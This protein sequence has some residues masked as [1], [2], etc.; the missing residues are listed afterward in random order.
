MAVLQGLCVYL[1]DP[2]VD[3]WDQHFDG[4]GP[5]GFI[6]K[7]GAIIGVGLDNTGNFAGVPRCCAIKRA[8]DGQILNTPAV[9]STATTGED[10]W[11]KIKIR[12]DIEQNNCDVTLG[13]HKV[14]DDVSFEGVT[15]PK[16]V[17]VGVCGATSRDKHFAIC[18][19]DVML[20]DDE[21]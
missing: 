12:F 1:V 2:S 11:R 9:L 14:L 10:E 16:T 8:S 21:D 20:L 6:G 5:L 13:D 17:C 15:I 18:V 19:N 4:S 3:G 7:K